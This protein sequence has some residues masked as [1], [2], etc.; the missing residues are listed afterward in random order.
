MRKILIPGLLAGFA[1]AV[2]G[3]I[4]GMGLHL[5]FPSVA[6]EYQNTALFRPWTDPIMNIY[7]ACPFILGLVLAVIWDKVKSVV[8]GSNFCAKGMYFGSG[9]F[10]VTISG[11]LINY[12][13]FP[14]S[15]LMV[16]TWYLAVLAEALTAGAVLA[17]MNK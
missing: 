15:I 6:L 12:A 11:I 13:S 3:M 9:Y 8:P 2:V 10:A 5:I 4:V 14:I 17:Y 1:M 7:W 16:I